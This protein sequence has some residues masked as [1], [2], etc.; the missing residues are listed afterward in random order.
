MSASRLRDGHKLIDRWP[1]EILG[2]PRRPMNDDAI[3][4]LV[5]AEPEM[6]PAIVLTR[7]AGSTVDDAPLREITRL[8]H[9]FRADR[10]AVAARSNERERDPVIA[11]VR[12][13]A[14]EQRRLI[15]IGHDDVER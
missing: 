3:D 4:P 2:Q 15:L 7:E 5:V 6:Q 11:A 10:A 8:E 1:L 13:V 14:V 9:D 12:I